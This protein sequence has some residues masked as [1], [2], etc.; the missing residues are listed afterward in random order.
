[1]MCARNYRKQRTREGVG[2]PGGVGAAVGSG[3]GRGGHTPAAAGFVL[4]VQRRSFGRLKGHV[5]LCGK[6]KFNLF[7]VMGEVVGAV[8]VQRYLY[9]IALVVPYC[10]LEAPGGGKAH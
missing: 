10:C 7:E 3:G 5:D 2:V 6:N 4:N 1:M 8:N 9:V